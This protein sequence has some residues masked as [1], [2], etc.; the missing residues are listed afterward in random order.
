MPDR[1]LDKDAARRFRQAAEK[2][3]YLSIVKDRDMIEAAPGLFSCTYKITHGQAA[4]EEP[5]ADTRTGTGTN[6][7][8]GSNA[9]TGVSAGA[10]G[11]TTRDTAA[12][13]L[14]QIA[15]LMAKMD[16]DA[17]FQFSRYPAKSCAETCLTCSVRGTS[18]DEADARFNQI[19]ADI[20]AACEVC[21]PGIRLQRLP[22]T[23]VLGLM[24]GIYHRGAT[25]GLLEQ[26][27]GED[28]SFA[29][30]KKYRLTTKELVSPASI[31]FERDFV[32]TDS[33]CIRVLSASVYSIAHDHETGVEGACGET[34]SDPSSSTP[35][36]DAFHPDE[37]GLTV[38]AHVRSLEAALLLKKIREEIAQY[39]EMAAK[40]GRKRTQEYRAKEEGSF[41]GRSDR[42]E[43]PESTENA[44]SSEM[45]GIYGRAGRNVRN[46]NSGKGNPGKGREGKVNQRRGK[47]GRQQDHVGYPDREEI[48][49]KEQFTAVLQDAAKHGEKIYQITFLFALSAPTPDELHDRTQDFL[50]RTGSPFFRI[51]PLDY[52]QEAGLAGILPLASCRVQ[53]SRVFPARPV[54]FLLSPFFGRAYAAGS[55]FGG[56]QDESLSPMEFYSIKMK[57]GRPKT[58]GQFK[59]KRTIQETI[60][61]LAACGEDG[62]FEL[63]PGMF[64]RMYAFSDINYHTATEEDQTGFLIR[65]SQLLNRFDASVRCQIVLNNKNVD[66]RGFRKDCL[67]SMRGDGLDDYRREYNA[68]VA[69]KMEEGRNNLKKE[70][71]LAVSIEAENLDAAKHAFSRLDPEIVNSFKEIGGSRAEALTTAERLEVLHDIYNIGHERGRLP[72][73]EALHRM[74]ASSKDL[75]AP[76]GFHFRRDWFMMGGMYCRVMYLMDLPN[77]LSDKFVTELSSVNCNLVISI[78]LEIIRQD[79]AVKL[80]RHQMLNINSNMQLAQQTASK[81]GYSM[82][83]VPQDLKQAQ[84]EANDLL[85]NLTGRNQKMF[86][87]TFTVLVFGRDYEDLQANTEILISTGRKYLCSLKKLNYQ[88]EDGL[89]ATLPYCFNRL[90]IKRT[91][92]TDSTIIFSPFDTQELMQPKGM[93]YGQNATSH[94]LIIFNRESSQNGNGWI[95]G[96]PGSGKS[97]AAK[98]EMANAFLNTEDDILII[99]PEREYSPLV[100]AFGGSIVRIAPGS[101][102]HLNP[103]DMDKDYGDDDDP[104]VL[105]SDFI[106]SLCES[107]IGGRYG[108]TPSQHAIIDRVVLIIYRDYLN[109][110]FDR[111]YLPTLLDFEHCL[112]AQPEREARELALAFEI[113]TKGSLD[114][115]AH[116]SNV[117]INNRFV[118]YD[119]KDIGSNIKTMAYLVV[120]D[121][122]WNRVVTNRKKGKKTW[123]YMD[124]IYILLDGHDESINF[125]RQIFSRGRKWGA[126]T[127]GITQNVEPLLQ[128]TVVTTMLSNSAFIQLLNQAPV[129]RDILATLL[130]IS[131]TQVSFI[132]NAPPGQGVLYIQGQ[133]IIPFRN[134]FSKQLAPKL[135]SVM[136]S[137]PDELMEEF[138]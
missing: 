87:M 71:Y 72:E 83:L 33:G 97:F 85:R 110:G 3:P 128:N 102:Y 123:I 2:V 47:S 129:D 120:L 20:N 81:N 132:N 130:H 103:L 57:A 54:A 9:D 76:S 137:K 37:N 122:I 113:Y 68:I 50:S 8:E 107:V 44:E 46:G 30:M 45:L 131:P 100:K 42:L 90:T 41:S 61:Y 53:A 115:F 27:H 60:P 93:Y 79:K 38:C 35:F 26:T 89:N 70:R 80:V 59:V 77:T 117:D 39:R 48:Q 135:Y 10:D 84:E 6:V 34:A 114:V 28:V 73:L 99:D 19:E 94:N 101:R 22:I 62:I 136:T 58:G 108:L 91:L 36:F 112:E 74:G 86:R 5:G 124:E 7:S 13:D 21:A 133:G 51:I 121:N 127:T 119:I 105:K 52:Q 4:Y 104:I 40:G 69:S 23:K 66:M 118:V 18:I 15:A 78:N 64:S 126:K 12:V 16:P 125:V 138:R 95:L 98:E 24:Y 1:K 14:G 43:S 109:H 56:G 88:Q 65:Y 111:Y 67:L 63:V 17:S 134:N 75:V 106:L 29:V 31:R 49:I 25:D 55:V 11:N 96:T 32:Q 82:D 92:T 116:E